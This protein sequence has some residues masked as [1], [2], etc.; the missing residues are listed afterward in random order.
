M[1]RKTLAWWAANQDIAA[2]VYQ[3]SFLPYL[4]GRKQRHIISIKLRLRKLCLYEVLL[5]GIGSVLVELDS[6]S[7]LDFGQVRAKRESASPREQVASYNVLA[8]PHWDMGVSSHG[9]VFDHQS[10]NPF[11]WLSLTM[12]A[13]QEVKTT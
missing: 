11:L 4:V 13:Y 3:T 1:L 5:I 12:G 2:M 9:S 6:R 8:I 7:D 10:Q